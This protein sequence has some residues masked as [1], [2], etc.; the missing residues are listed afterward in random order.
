MH[1]VCV[2][3][4]DCTTGNCQDGACARPPLTVFDF[5]GGACVLVTLLLAVRLR[6][7]KADRSA[8]R[9]AADADAAAKPA[10]PTGEAIVYAAWVARVATR[11]RGQLLRL[12]VLAGLDLGTDLAALGTLPTEGGGAG[13]AFGGDLRGAAVTFLAVAVGAGAVAVAWAL[14][15]HRF[16]A[17]VAHRPVEILCGTHFCSDRNA[18]PSALAHSC[19]PDPHI[20]AESPAIFATG[21]RRPSPAC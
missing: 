18:R 1:E 16:A 14:C 2:V 20:P 3:A 4:S 19:V 10:K 9:S 13:A 21:T 7:L 11:G 8:D 15:R 12:V 5:A 17:H 6:R